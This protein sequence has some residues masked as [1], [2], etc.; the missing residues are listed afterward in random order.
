[1]VTKRSNWPASAI[2]RPAHMAAAPF[3]NTGCVGKN[4]TAAMAIKIRLRYLKKK[5]PRATIDTSFNGDHAGE[6]VPFEKCID[7]FESDLFQ[8]V[9]IFIQ[10]VRDQN[11]LQ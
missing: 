11:I 2:T 5:L 10:F 1:M 7:V 9:D 8:Q 6:V 3:P 4:N